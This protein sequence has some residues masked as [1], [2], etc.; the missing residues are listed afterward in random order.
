MTAPTRALPEGTSYRDGGC[1]HHPSCL[2]CPFAECVLDV[3]LRLQRAEE[4]RAKVHALQALGKQFHE[5]AA[6]TGI[7]LRTVQRLSAAYVPQRRRRT[8]TERETISARL[9]QELPR[10]FPPGTEWPSGAAKALAA[11]FDCPQSLVSAIRAE[12][13]L[14]ASLDAHLRRFARLAR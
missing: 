7:S 10:R 2:T 6:E 1:A 9:R 8:R 13:G 12:L 14:T 11:E 3:P 4:R 5:I